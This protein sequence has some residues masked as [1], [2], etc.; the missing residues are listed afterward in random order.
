[1]AFRSDVSRGMGLNPTLIRAISA[2]A[3]TLLCGASTAAVGPIAFLRLAV[4]HA[5]RALTGPD[6]RW[7]LPL[8]TLA[9]PGLLLGADVVGRVLLSPD[10]L[11]VGVVTSFL[12]APVLIALVTRR[13]PVR[14]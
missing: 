12:G 13:K 9:A 10:E 5:V 6:D 2:V 4:P 3:Y 7:V 14:L 11:R 8:S 1:M